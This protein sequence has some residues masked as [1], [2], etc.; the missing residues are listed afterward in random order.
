LNRGGEEKG[1]AA[2]DFK[3]FCHSCAAPLVPDFTGP[4]DNFCKYC[5]DEQG[6]V[7][8]REATQV[9][10]AKWFMSWQPGLDQQVAMERAE[11]YMKAMPHWAE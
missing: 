9:G 6:N 1:K 8:P 4:V 11:H 10:I 7:N 5:T 3:G 2:M